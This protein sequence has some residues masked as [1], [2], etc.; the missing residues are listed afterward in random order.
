MENIENDTQI[1][2]NYFKESNRFFKVDLSVYDFL[3]KAKKETGVYVGDYKYI[4]NGEIIRGRE[5]EYT[6]HLV[7]HIGV[8]VYRVFCINGFVDL[9]LSHDKQKD[10][11]FLSD[12][13]DAP[14]FFPFFD[15]IDLFGDVKN[16]KIKTIN[17]SNCELITIECECGYH[18]G[19]DFTFIDQV[20]DFETLCPS[21]KK[22]IDTSEIE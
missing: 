4:L 3:I 12:F 11:L 8:S 20:T 16:A 15:N 6:E 21:C 10:Y 14:S 7:S 22:I 18:M 19:I 5:H 2:T 17:P 9:C 13:K 1:I